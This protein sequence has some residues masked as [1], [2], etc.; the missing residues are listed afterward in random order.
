MEAN[1][2]T[3]ATTVSG[4]A[5]RL[6]ALL[7]PS[8]PT[9]PTEPAKSQE[10]T[11]ADAQVDTPTGDTQPVQKYKVPYKGQEEELT[12]DELIK[13]NM[14]ERDYRHGTMDLADKRRDLEAKGKKLDE[15]LEDARL[16]L[17]DELA[18]L[19]SPE[20][21]ELEQTDPDAYLKEMRR[22]QRKVDRFNKRKTERQ[23]QL[24]A[25]RAEL[26]T[27]EREAMLKA[28]PDWL[29]DAKLQAEAPKVIGTLKDVGFGDKELPDLVDHRIMV[30]ARKAFL[31][32]QIQ[33]QKPEGKKVVTAPKVAKPGA[34]VDAETAPNKRLEQA[35]QQ[36]KS[37][38]SRK[39]AAAAIRAMFKN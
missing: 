27:K 12:L 15:Q 2:D 22:V 5:E 26:T 35:R 39:D 28:I 25:Q 23:E 19:N 30:L 13:G 9:P 38:G 7:N 21:Q 37:T 20:M 17:E 1:Q 36:L 14:M 24:Q 3:G 32:D 10:G 34:S 31:Y 4:A 11:E 29:D 16:L 6:H 33:S 8:E 18:A